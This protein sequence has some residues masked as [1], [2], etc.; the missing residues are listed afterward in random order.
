MQ[1]ILNTG[2][3]NYCK[4]KSN[5]C[6]ELR[7]DSERNCA[8]LFLWLPHVSTWQKKRFIARMRIWT[9]W[10]IV[11]DVGHVPKG[12]G[13]MITKSE[14]ELGTV[15]P[16][17]KLVKGDFLRSNTHKSPLAM[18]V[19]HYMKLIEKS[20]ELNYLDTLVDIALETWLKR[21]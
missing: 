20:E 10:K 15:R 14:W 8:A 1:E 9:D 7:F 11:S 16:L 2:S 19:T 12:T 3:I 5:P 6:A 21:L 13:R 17:K 18:K 4:G